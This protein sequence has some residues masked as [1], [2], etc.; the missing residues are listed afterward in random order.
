MRQDASTKEPVSNR[1]HM[2]HRPVTGMDVLAHCH[3][4][5]LT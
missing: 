4:I 2:H 3:T 5:L 1:Y